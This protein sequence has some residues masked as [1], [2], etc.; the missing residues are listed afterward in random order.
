LRAEAGEV[1]RIATLSLGT[2]DRPHP[3]TELLRSRLIARGYVEGK[4]IAISFRRPSVGQPIPEFAATIV[5]AKPSIIVANTSTLA[6]ALRKLTTTIPILIVSG[7]DPVGEGLAQSLAR[8]GGNVTGLTTQHDEL[9][10]KKVELIRHVLPGAHRVLGLR[11]PPL[12]AVLARMAE[13]YA[14][15]MAQLGFSMV[16]VD[17]IGRDDIERVRAA[18]AEHRPDAMLMFSNPTVTNQD[19][20]LAELSLAMRVPLFASQGYIAEYGALASYGSDPNALWERSVD[21]V[22]RLL[23]GADPATMPIEQPTRFERVIN[24]R[25]AR[26]LG[27]EIPSVAVAIADR[28]ID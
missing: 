21:Y 20:P 18:I 26:A 9:A 19:R 27:I 24:L 22:D 15:P 5:D 28:V 11:G 1:R 17:L 12:T 3:Y 2:I 6:V 16:P 14:A 8:P 23:K 4:D 10:G 25:A 13:Q 7:Y